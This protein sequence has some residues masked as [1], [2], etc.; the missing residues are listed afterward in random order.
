M[1]GFIA[2]FGTGEWAVR[3]VGGSGDGTI[4]CWGYNEYGQLGY[5]D[6]KHRGASSTEMGMGLPAI[7]LGAGRKVVS[8]SAGEFNTCALLDDATVKCWGLNSRGQLGYGDS[9]DRG[10]S[11]NEMGAHLP[12]IDLGSGRTAASVSMG[13]TRACAILAVGA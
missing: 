2:G 6:S 3:G 5:S 12:A 4:K 13:D 7:D 11:R 8:V 9:S 10:D 1:L